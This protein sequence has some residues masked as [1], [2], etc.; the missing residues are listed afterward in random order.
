MGLK[1]GWDEVSGYLQS[2]A[3]NVSQVDGVSD[4]APTCLLGVLWR[5]GSE[6][7]QWSL[8]TVLSGNKMFPSSHPA[9]RYFSSS[10]YATGAF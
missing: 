4:I 7:E 5:E 3:D 9:A 2:G 1:I 8:P 10:P 6:E